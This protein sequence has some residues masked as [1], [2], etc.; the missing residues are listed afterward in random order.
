VRYLNLIENIRDWWVFFEYKFGLKTADPILLHSRNGVNI[1]IPL[2]LL[3]AFKE[4]FLENCYIHGLNKLY[5][6]PPNPVVIDIGANGGFF[7]L[8]AAARFRNPKIFAYEPI[9]FNYKQLEANAKLNE[10]FDIHPFQMA[11]AAQAGSVKMLFEGPQAFTT[12]AHISRDGKTQP[13]M[14]NFIEV[15]CTTLANIFAENK[16]RQCDFL[17]MDCE[18]AEFEILQNCPDECLSRISVLAMENHGDVKTLI[19]FFTSKKFR[20]FETGKARGMLWAYRP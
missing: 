2:R 13:E 20:T 15:S 6:V 4:I 19:D 1:Q 10:A 16:I 3:H 14:Q 11:V 8:F 12:T 7:T 5:H 18:G 17:K 9:P